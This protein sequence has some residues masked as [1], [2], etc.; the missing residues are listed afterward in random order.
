[1]VL[2]VSLIAPRPLLMEPVVSSPGTSSSA[3]ERRQGS[4]GWMGG[5]GEWRCVVYAMHVRKHGDGVCGGFAV[6]DG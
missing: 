2:V 3:C 4:V 6:D 5:R 1:M